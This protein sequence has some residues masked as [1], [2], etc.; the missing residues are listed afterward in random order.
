[1]MGF[2]PSI[3]KDRNQKWYLTLPISGKLDTINGF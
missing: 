3:M 2:V 1:M